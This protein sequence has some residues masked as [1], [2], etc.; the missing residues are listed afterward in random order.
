MIDI[1]D[2][3]TQ[4]TML[5]VTYERLTIAIGFGQLRELK[6]NSNLNLNLNMDRFQV[7]L[8]SMDCGSTMKH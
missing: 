8:L 1:K 6:L 7:L 2:V 3:Y 4:T 5:S